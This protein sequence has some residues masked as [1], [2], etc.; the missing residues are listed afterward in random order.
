MEKRYEIKASSQDPQPSTAPQ[1]QLTP[2]QLEVLELL[3]EGLPNKLIGRQ[4]DIACGT[5]THMRFTRSFVC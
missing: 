1:E 3:C 4:L 2:R 5:V